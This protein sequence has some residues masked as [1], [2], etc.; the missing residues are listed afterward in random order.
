[1][2]PKNLLNSQTDYTDHELADPRTGQTNQVQ[3]SDLDRWGFIKREKWNHLTKPREGNGLCSFYGPTNRIEME[4]QQVA[5]KKRKCKK[6]NQKPAKKKKENI[7]TRLRR[8]AKRIQ[9]GELSEH[10]LQRIIRRLGHRI[11]RGTI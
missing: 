1:M 3:A 7:Q 9:H 6:Q 2:I 10:R 11:R 8:L 5:K 4:I